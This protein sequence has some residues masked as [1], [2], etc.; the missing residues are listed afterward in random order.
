MRQLIW[1]PLAFVFGLTLLAMP[2]LGANTTPAEKAYATGKTLYDNGLD[3]QAVDQLQKYLTDYPNE[4]RVPEATFMLAH[5][6]QRQQDFTKALASFQQVVAKAT[7]PEYTDLRAKA[8]FQMGECYFTTQD[9]EK[10]SRSYTNSLTLSG[11]LLTTAKPEERGKLTDQIVRAQYWLA[12][13]LYQGGHLEDALPEYGKV[14]GINTQHAFAPWSL[15]SVGIIELRLTEDGKATTAL[16]HYGKAIKALEGVL[17]QYGTSEVVGEARLALGFSYAGRSRLGSANKDVDCRKAVETFSAVLEDKKATPTSKLQATLALAQ[18]YFDL[19]DY[20]KSAETYAAALAMPEVKAGSRQA[21]DTTMQRGHALYN[22]G[23]YAEAAAE[24][25]KVADSKLPELSVQG[26]YWLGNSCYQ[27]ATTAKD[28]KAYNDA[29]SAFKRFLTAAGDTHPQA[30]RAALLVAFSQEDLA[31]LGDETARGKTLA[32]FK[33]LMD[34]WPNTREARQAQDGIARLTVTMSVDDLQK[35]VGQLPPGVATWGA[36]LRLAREEFV[37]GK[38]ENAAIA[39]KS[40]LD[41]KPAPTGDLL[42]QASYLVGASLQKQNK[43][44]DAIDYYKKVLDTVKT[45]DLATF[46]RRGLTQA[47][48]DTKRFQDAVDS[49]LALTA[50]QMPNKE[51]EKAEAFMLLAEA[52]LGLGKT[53]DATATYQKIAKDYPNSPLVP[54]AMMGIAWATESSNQDLAIATYRDLVL[55]FPDSEIVPQAFFRLGVTLNK[56][57]EYEAAITAFKQVPATDKI[58][59]Q[60]AYA[61][62]WAY[63]DQKNKTKEANDQFQLVADKFPTSPLAADSLYRIGESILQDKKDYAEAMRYF[64][65]ALDLSKQDILTGMVAYKLG[66]CAYY[67]E[68]YSVAVNAFGKVTANYPTSDY[69]AES[70]FWKAASLEKQGTATATAARDAYIQYVTKYPGQLYVL[71]AALGAGRSAQAAKQYAI[72][73]SDLQKTLDLCTAELKGSD[74]N[75]LKDRQKRA[76]NVEPEAQYFM[77]QSYFEEKKYDEALKEF[78]GVS[79]YLLEPWYSNSLLQMARCSALSGN[80]EH[81]AHTL[82]LLKDNFKN[83]E[84]AKQADEVAKELGVTLED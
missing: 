67:S 69:A 78:A 49:A 21:M 79:V 39:A 24:Y 29:I 55:K 8:H 48:L 84:A 7:A 32:A 25:G 35:V 82:Q 31:G 45:G 28:T 75:N 2:A 10:A 40:V 27:Q 19:N 68:Q 20:A 9:F 64:N 3:K 43:A 11:K 30:S 63:F 56:K 65:R 70:L 72:A 77:G 73:R 34:K 42:A 17:T 46:A 18:A 12:E 74:N 66:V 5:C 76:K 41:G 38:Y 1:V 36:N 62:A 47:Y 44:G 58:A 57:G 51:K 6:Y 52:Y 4:V 54:S 50:I 15:Y 16:D 83:S 80:K 13:S 53:A 33:E 60:A 61:I 23:R 37:A 26:L 71:D 14:A 59:D 81:A 22:G